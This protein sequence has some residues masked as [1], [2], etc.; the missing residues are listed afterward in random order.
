MAD[1]K[2]QCQGL[3]PHADAPWPS[4]LGKTLARKAESSGQIGMEDCQKKVS[5]ETV[6]KRPTKA[7]PSPAGMRIVR[8]KETRVAV[9]GDLYRR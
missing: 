8:I 9:V 7:P 2:Y 5:I 3:T 6:R 1:V 4:A